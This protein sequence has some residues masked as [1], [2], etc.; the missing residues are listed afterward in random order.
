M[1]K[2]HFCNSIKHKAVNSVT[3][4]PK[5]HSD[6]HKGDLCVDFKFKSDELSNLFPNQF[7]HLSPMHLMSH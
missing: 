2:L 7:E 3:I 4:L 6:Y 5:E 1:V